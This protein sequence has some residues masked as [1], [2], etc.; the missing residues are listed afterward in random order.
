MDEL[1]ADLDE[2]RENSEAHFAELFASASRSAEVLGTVLK[3]QRVPGVRGC[4]TSGMT[5]EQYYRVNAYNHVLDLLRQD[6]RSRFKSMA[7]DMYSRLSALLP[8]PIRAKPE[9]LPTLTTIKPCLTLYESLLPFHTDSTVQ[10]ELKLWCKR[11][12]RHDGPIPVSVIECIE[13][14]DG[15]PVVSVLLSILAVIPVTSCTPERVF[16]KVK[17]TL[18]KI[19]STMTESRLQD[20]ILIQSNRGKLPTTEEILQRFASRP[21]KRGHF[22]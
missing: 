13:C 12:A 10:T 19:R 4:A 22:F 21:G 8:A 17:T 2:R 3:L 6:I 9:S 7:N 16:S 14:A 5:V 18:T 20:I 15:F 11:W 1:L